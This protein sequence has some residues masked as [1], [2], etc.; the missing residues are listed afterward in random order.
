MSG[1]PRRRALVFAVGLTLI[2]A[3]LAGLLARLS[4]FN[5]LSFGHYYL[6]EDASGAAPLFAHGVLR[7]LFAVVAGCYLL[8]PAGVAGYYAVQGERHPLFYVALA[9]VAIIGLPGLLAAVPLLF[10]QPTSAT[11]RL[12]AVAL[13]IAIAAA[14]GIAIRRGPDDPEEGVPWFVFANVGLV[15]VFVLGMVHGGVLAGGVASGLIEQHRVGYPGVEFEASYA[16]VD[17]DRGVL[18]IRHENGRPTPPGRIHVEG[19][20]FA[21]VESV[22]QSTPGP[23]RGETS[24]GPQDG[25]VVSEG[26]A[27]EVGVQ[28]DCRV[29]VVYRYDSTST[30][31]TEYECAELRGDD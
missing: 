26:D 29:L 14:F 31:I 17:G 28:A 5:V 3:V 12:L 18:T 7:V 6:A 16:A 27:V 10:V 21:D 11:L 25:P 2:V 20:G 19:E 15:G 4:L 22:D 8:V 24:S 23:W 30:V 13:V 1:R 9:A